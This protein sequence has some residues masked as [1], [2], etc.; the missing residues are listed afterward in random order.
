VT[1]SRKNLISLEHTTYYHCTTRCVRRAFLCG[2]DRY[3]GQS[4]EHR[5]Q[6]LEDRLKYLSGVFG[7]DLLAYAIMSN[8]YHVV[9]RINIESASAWT[10]EEVTR[11]WGLIFSVCE[12]GVTQETIDQWRGRLSDLSWFM[13]CL[14][15]SMARRANREDCCK[16]RFWEGRFKSQALLDETAVLKC[17]AYVDLNPIRAKIAITPESA[18]YTSIKCRIDG[19]DQHLMHFASAAPAGTPSIPI[20]YKDYLQLLDWT[21]R[22]LRRDKRGRIPADL[23]PILE[24]LKLP[25]D[26]WID[27][28]QHYGRWYYRAVGSLQ[29]L[30]SYCE[31]LGQQWLKGAGRA[32]SLLRY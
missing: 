28:M 26:Q 10:D 24:R 27:E 13:R 19:D 1:I 3:S 2:R 32:Q 25:P 20:A 29:A 30:A 12:V 17:M 8:H 6:W 15:E 14:N 9:V 18:P 22:V 16:G 23:P 4:F 21:G 7:I 31:M 11:R 5:K